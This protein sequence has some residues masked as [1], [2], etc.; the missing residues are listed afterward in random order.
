[1]CHDSIVLFAV[2]K[3][4]RLELLGRQAIMQVFARPVPGS[5]G[6]P[7]PQMSDKF[8]LWGIGRRSEEFEGASFAGVRLGWR[9]QRKK[10]IGILTT[11]IRTVIF[12]GFTASREYQEPDLTSSLIGAPHN[13]QR[14]K[15]M[16]R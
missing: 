13:E 11:V 4:D 3:Y 8:K 9:K 1:M 7:C 15:V 5:M 6:K 16:L 2:C 10:V 12:K 14:T